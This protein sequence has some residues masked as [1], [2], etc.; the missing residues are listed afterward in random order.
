[1]N[2]IILE[3]KEALQYRYELFLGELKRTNMSEGMI[4]LQL[5]E[6]LGGH[7]SYLL[8]ALDKIS[9]RT[10]LLSFCYSAYLVLCDMSKTKLKNSGRTLP[11][12]NTEVCISFADIQKLE[13][14]N[15][16]RL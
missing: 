14:M 16:E 2:A 15:N 9:D 10:G 13:Q 6:L 4:H 7:Y 5:R 11:L 8:R 1:M 3:S 12:K